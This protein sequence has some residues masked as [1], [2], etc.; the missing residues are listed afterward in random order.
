MI[1][2]SVKR[3]GT[4]LQKTAQNMSPG[5]IRQNNVDHCVKP[6]SEKL[7]KAYEPKPWS[8]VITLGK[9]QLRNENGQ[10]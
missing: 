9:P 1:T 5:A 3:A 4:A 10:I 7:N 6:F 2:K 8:K